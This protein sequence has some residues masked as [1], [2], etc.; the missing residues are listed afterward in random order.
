[1]TTIEINKSL[2][3]AATEGKADLVR[4]LISYG[5]DVNTT[6]NEGDT[7]LS[8]IIKRG[9]F[10]SG[11]QWDCVKLLMVAGAVTTPAVIQ[12]ALHVRN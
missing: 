3:E 5:A 11:R 1:M 2:L 8:I 4:E 6:N 12:T 10:W 9:E 7:A